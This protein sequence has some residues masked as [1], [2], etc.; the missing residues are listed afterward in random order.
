MEKDPSLGHVGWQSAGV[1]LG[2]AATV[3]AGTG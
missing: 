1:L 3:Q 2:R